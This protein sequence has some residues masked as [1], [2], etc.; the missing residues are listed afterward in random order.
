MTWIS[1]VAG[2][3]PWW[4]KIAGKVVLSRLPVSG[5]VWQKIGLFSPG[6]M[7]RPDYAIGVF[8]FHYRAA[9]SPAAGFSYLEL[10]PGDS[11]ASA[12]VGKAYGAAR[13][14]LVD[15]GSYASRD[16]DLYR[17]V[18]RRLAAER[19][20]TDLSVLRDAP[21]LDALLQAC[22][23]TFLEQGLAS[24]KQV[25]AESCDFIFS[26][27]VLEHVP[28]GEFDAVMGELHRIL[29]PGGVATHRVD[30]RDHLGGG[31]NNLRFSADLWESPWFALRSGFYTN[32]LRLSVMTARLQAAGFAVE[33]SQRSS[34]PAP[35]IARGLLDGGFQGLSEEDLMTDQAHIL[36]RKP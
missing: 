26:E 29:K 23:T 1:S 17:E 18:V 16:M 33:V 30:F 14:W 20:G 10:G 27:A 21:G 12:V 7:W 6:L 19:P 3:L 28:L 5:K 22:A 24:L 35:P 31:W 8:D 25:P 11:V 36:A 32:R 9:G 15:S 13:A 4:A 34:W 2:K